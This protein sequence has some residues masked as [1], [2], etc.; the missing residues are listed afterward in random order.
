MSYKLKHESISTFSTQVAA[1]ICSKIFTNSEKIDG[2]S[3]TSMTKVR[4]VN[5]FVVRSLFSKWQDEMRK[6]ESPY[7]DFENKEVRK[8]LNVFMDTLSNHISVGQEH[9]EP[10]LVEALEESVLLIFEPKTYLRQSVDIDTN[11]LKGDLKYIKC[12]QKSF[13]ELSEKELTINTI[14]HHVKVLANPFENILPTE[15]LEE[16]EASSM[17]DL[18]FSR[19][20]VITEKVVIQVKEKSGQIEESQQNRYIKPEETKEKATETIN[21][22]FNGNSNATTLADKLQKKVIQSIDKSLSLNERIMFTNSLFKG[23]KELMSEALSQIDTA[24]SLSEAVDIAMSFNKG[25]KMDSYEI[26]AFMEVIERKFN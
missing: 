4:Q 23:D 20:E 13:K 1:Q 9:L 24:G 21:D 17:L 2:E 7:F 8:G 22:K 12:H 11:F 15:F 10:L 5:S 25:W 16:L 6:L 14:G 18:L 3:I 26:E 19:E